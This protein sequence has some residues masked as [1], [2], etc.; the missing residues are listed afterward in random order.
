MPKQEIVGTHANGRERWVLGDG[1]ML[2]G[3]HPVAVECLE[4]SCVIHNPSD[5][6]M[7]GW[8]LRITSPGGL[9]QRVCT[10]GA[11]HPDPDSLDYFV[12]NKLF[13]QVAEGFHTCDGCCSASA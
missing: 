9:M 10:H 8:S 5:H 11:Y 13:D 7:R 6:H 3:V 1:Q 2:L 4:H 12:R